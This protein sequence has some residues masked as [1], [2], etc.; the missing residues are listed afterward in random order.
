MA[1]LDME[2]L[3]VELAE[4]VRTRFFGKYRGLVK[5]NQDPAN[6]GRIRALVPEVLSDVLSGWALPCAPYAGDGEG[7]FMIPPVG[8]GVWIEFESGDVSRPVWSGCWWSEDK[9]P[10]DSSGS[11]AAPPL[12]IIRSE[13]G[14]MAAFDDGAQTISLSDRNG[15]NLVKIQVQPGLITIQGTVKVVVEAPQIELVANAAHPLVF[16]D[17]LLQYLGQIVALY[18]SHV[19]VPPA[20]TP[21]PPLPPPVPAMLSLKV[22]TG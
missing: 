15:N 6:L 9:L 16:G 10:K 20:M 1:D 2:K 17:Q 11:A 3:V 19:H 8:A 5:D 4:Q 22:K 21:V 7:Q 14:L 13:T 12:K 18:G